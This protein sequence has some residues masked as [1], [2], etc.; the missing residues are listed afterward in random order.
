VLVTITHGAFR[1]VV[2]GTQVVARG[3][4]TVL[5]PTPRGTVT[6][7]TCYP[8]SYIG[9][10]PQRFVVRAALQSDR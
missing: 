8:F 4:V 7:I 5:D 1:Y 6:L 9:G 2:T 10:A 3:D